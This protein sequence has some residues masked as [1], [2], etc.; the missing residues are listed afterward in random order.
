MTPEDR[1]SDLEKQVQQLR[2]M[3]E[4]GLDVIQNIGG[5]ERMYQA[6]VVALMESHPD[7]EAMAAAVTHHLEKQY[8]SIH[9]VTLPESHVQGA[10]SAH[11]WLTAV[12]QE[13][14]RRHRGG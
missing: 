4:G 13:T 12:V 10:Q 11:T 8:T 14:L 5:G 3:F 1:I 2:Q 7:P 9:F 6:V